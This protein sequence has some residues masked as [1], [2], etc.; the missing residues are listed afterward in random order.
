MKDA[1]T[2]NVDARRRPIRPMPRTFSVGTCRGRTVEKQCLEGS[3]KRGDTLKCL[4]KGEADDCAEC[5]PLFSFMIIGGPQGHEHSFQSR[6]S[7]QGGSM[8]GM[9]S[10]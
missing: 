6:H 7:G 2:G 9:E 1:R 3:E 5:P 8:L 10:T 4:F